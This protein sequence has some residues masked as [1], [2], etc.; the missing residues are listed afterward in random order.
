MAD[1]GALEAAGA[2]A[3]GG[4]GPFS[5][6]ART[7]YAALVTM[8]WRMFVIGL[9]SIRGLFEL[10]ASGIS[11]MVF[12]V[13]GLGMG[14][15]LGATSYML[16]Q[17]SMWTYLPIEFWVVCFIWQT[18]PV[19]LASFQ[20]QFDLGGLLRFPVSFGSFFMLYVI[21]GLGDV[22]TVLGGLCCL[23]IWVGTRLARPDLSGW[24]ALGLAAFAVFNILLARSILAWIDRWLA[25][26]RTREIVSALFLLLFL[27]L[28]LMNPA[29]R[30]AVHEGP[31]GRMP[32]AESERVPLVELRPWMKTA[33][34]VQ[35]WL[36]PGLAG[37]AV[38]RAAER[39]PAGAA[40]L[41][42]ALGLWVLAVGGVLGARLRA[43]YRGENL[44]EAPSLKKM[45]RREGGW[46]L[47]GSGPV[48]AGME[49]ELRTLLRSMPLLYSLGLPMLM[50][51][52]IAS[53]FHNGASMAKHPFQLAL[54]VCVAYGLMGFTRLIYNNLGIEG[55]GIQLVF[56][57]P[58]PVRAVLLAKNLLHAILFAVV[59][60]V[61]G[62]L[63]I[64]RLGL[65]D[66]VVLGATV[67]WLL[68]ALPAN[69]AVGNIFSLTMP[70]HVNP[71]R[72]TRQRGSAASALLSM[73]IQ[74]TLLGVGAAVFGLCVADG[75]LWLAIPILLALAGAAVYAW[76]RVLGNADSM[77]NERRDL[78]MDTLGKA[79]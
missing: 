66:G 37:V 38:Q 76:M 48:A 8:R 58:T 55:K 51:F 44:G 69:L 25:Q 61:S 26:R 22:S 32:P 70:Y 49:K 53:L 29:L 18:V 62:I 64:L 39:Q 6:L 27:G 2:A 78:L 46:L 42:G 79:E 36:P 4:T 7:Q 77:A 14:I 15:G 34:A 43:E 30:P 10:G 45:E 65:P 20:D 72:L 19:A 47:D 21:F 60:V 74:M 28:Q 59:S 54:P 57:S 35:V 5:R 23:G 12:S 50:V 56:L 63:A 75:R 68:F 73:L 71:G 3:A 9:R 31:I 17:R 52:V 67:A 41:L 40:G 13:M 33:I 16:A 24:L 11:L 1:L